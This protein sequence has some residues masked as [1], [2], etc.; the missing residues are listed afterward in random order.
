MLG[1]LFASYTALTPKLK[2]FGK[3]RIGVTAPTVA[4]EAKLFRVN[5]EM[6]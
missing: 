4:P 3:F 2:D 1:S 5:W 6:V